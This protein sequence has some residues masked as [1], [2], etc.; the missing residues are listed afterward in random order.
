[1]GREQRAREARGETG[2]RWKPEREAPRDHLHLAVHVVFK[3]PCAPPG[4]HTLMTAQRLDGRWVLDTQ[5]DVEII[6]FLEIPEPSG[7]RQHRH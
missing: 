6:E 5:H 2:L 7:F 4:G 3:C 1:M